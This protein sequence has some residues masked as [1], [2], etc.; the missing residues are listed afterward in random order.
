MKNVLAS[1][2]N[3]LVKYNITIE[4]C[5]VPENMHTPPQKGLEFP[6]IGGGEGSG[7]FCEIKTFKVWNV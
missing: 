7:G 2:S 5:A 4:Y 6:G 3:H 1:V